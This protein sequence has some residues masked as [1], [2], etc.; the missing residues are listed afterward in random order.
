MSGAHALRALLGP[1]RVGRQVELRLMRDGQV[2]SRQL[3]IAPQP[4]D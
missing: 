1:E 2:E 3:T 4:A